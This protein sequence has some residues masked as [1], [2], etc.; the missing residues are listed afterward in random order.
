MTVKSPRTVKQ[1]LA[2]AACL[3]AAGFSQALAY[4]ESDMM[5]TLRDPLIPGV[6]NA[7]DWQMAPLGDPP[8]MGSGDIPPAV[9][10]GDYG[11]PFAPAS[12]VPG[13]PL[14]VGGDKEPVNAAVSPYLVAPS[15]T[16]GQDMGSINGSSGGY[17]LQAPVA[18][19]NI[20]SNGGMSGSAPTQRWGGQRSYDYGKPANV[21]PYS[22]ALTDYGQRLIDKPDLHAYPVASEDGPKT[23]GSARVINGQYGQTTQD[24]YGQRVL[25]KDQRQV[26]TV[27]PY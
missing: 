3:F 22:S 8:A 25:F 13:M 7:S 26:Q 18:L 20:N 23:R 4:G 16:E 5:T 14:Q 27:A 17:G 15:S 12:Q 9:T 1:T 2:L 11:A 24:L 6:P 21:R 19:V 10:A